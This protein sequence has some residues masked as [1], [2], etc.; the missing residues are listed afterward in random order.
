MSC[1]MEGKYEYG[2][3]MYLKWKKLGINLVLKSKM[4]D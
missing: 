3:G 4:W 1:I 2:S